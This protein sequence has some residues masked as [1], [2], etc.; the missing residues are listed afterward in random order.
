[1][2]VPSWDSF[3]ARTRLGHLL[4]LPDGE[5]GAFSEEAARLTG[6]YLQDVVQALKRQTTAVLKAR[7]LKARVERKKAK[8]R[9]EANGTRASL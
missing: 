8:A 4:L 2:V 7:E 9:Q 5:A 6:G 3:Q 1:M